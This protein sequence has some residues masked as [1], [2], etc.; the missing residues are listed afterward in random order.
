MSFRR[1]LSGV[2]TVRGGVGLGRVS[3]GVRV[4]E[5]VRFLRA[6]GRLAKKPTY[7]AER[8]DCGCGAGVT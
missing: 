7:L 8:V 2:G 4:G 5:G 6:A 1:A 3:G